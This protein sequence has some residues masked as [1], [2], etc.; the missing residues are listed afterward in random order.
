[1]T[2]VVKTHLEQDAFD[3]T[4]AL[5]GFAFD[6]DRLKA[7]FDH[8]KQDGSDPFP[9]WWYD[10]S[11]RTDERKIKLFLST[12]AATPENV[13]QYYVLGKRLKEAKRQSPGYGVGEII[14]DPEVV[15]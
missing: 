10:D 9:T 6:I 15:A 12:E 7:D 4:S 11:Q 1:M 14:P 13:G 2:E 8:A 3:I 5:D